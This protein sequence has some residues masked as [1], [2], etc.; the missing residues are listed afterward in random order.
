MGEQFD[1]EAEGGAIGNEFGEEWY[2]TG[3]QRNVD[4]AEPLGDI[5]RNFFTGRG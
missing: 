4:G 1:E 5:E 2:S 3:P